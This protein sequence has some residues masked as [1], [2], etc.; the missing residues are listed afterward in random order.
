M[1]GDTADASAAPE[2]VTITHHGRPQAVVIPVDEYEALEET[3]EILSDDDTS[4]RS[5]EDWTTWLL[6][7]TPSANR[8]ATH[9]SAT[10]FEDG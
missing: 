4:P 1:G 7:S 6:H 9:R 3:A 5:S 8:N 10:E 2:H